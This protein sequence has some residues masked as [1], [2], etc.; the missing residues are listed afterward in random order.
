MN[1][2]AKMMAA[3][4]MLAIGLLLSAE[5][6]AEARQNMQPSGR[7]MQMA[8]QA[9]VYGGEIIRVDHNDVS[10]SW[11][12]AVDPRVTGYEVVFGNDPDVL[13]KKRQVDLGVTSITIEDLGQGK[14]WYFAVR[15][16]GKIGKKK[17]YSDETNI[18]SK[19]IPKVKG[20]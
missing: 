9:E 3:N 12:P 7:V 5:Q 1:T 17:A 15:S 18:V 19:Y 20:H 6:S 4:G 10:L 16:V 14:T 11:S 8:G 2:G 13:G